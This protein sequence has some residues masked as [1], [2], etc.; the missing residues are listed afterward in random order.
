MKHIKTASVV[1]PLHYQDANNTPVTASVLVEIDREGQTVIT[2]QG[3]KH[4]NALLDM[5]LLGV[6]TGFNTAQQPP[7]KGFPG[8][9]VEV[10][11]EPSEVNFTNEELCMMHVPIQ[12][13][14]TKEPWCR[15]CGLNKNYDQPRTISFSY[16]TL[17]IDDSL[18]KYE[19]RPNEG[20]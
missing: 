14:D 7:Q 11:M 17:R 4:A 5:V 19:E 16:R 3:V 20:P 2:I 9:N 12:H 8:D 6:L 10:T 18:R 13:R 15:R 1:L